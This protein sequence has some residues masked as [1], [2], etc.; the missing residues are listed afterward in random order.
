MTTTFILAFII[1][2]I[3]LSCLVCVVVCMAS[4]RFSA[5]VEQREAV[6]GTRA[7]SKPRMRPVEGSASP[8]NAKA[9]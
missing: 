6:Q 4:S 2:W 5:Q 7:R 3:G 1:G 9:G 8:V